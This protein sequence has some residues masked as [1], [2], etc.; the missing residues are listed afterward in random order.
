MTYLADSYVYR[1]G[2]KRGELI[3][4]V[5][6]WPCQ[7]I[8]DFAIIRSPMSSRGDVDTSGQESCEAYLALSHI[9]VICVNTVN[10][11]KGTRGLVHLKLI[12]GHFCSVNRLFPCNL[13]HQCPIAGGTHSLAY[14]HYIDITHLAVNEDERVR[15]DLAQNV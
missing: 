10:K 12:V 2:A 8:G 9:Y 13:A 6:A 7:A 14:C 15:I 3:I 11:T 1:I 5:V 4:A